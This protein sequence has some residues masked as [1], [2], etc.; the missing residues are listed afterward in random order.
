MVVVL[1]ALLVCGA[2]F[3]RSAH[4]HFWWEHVPGFFALFGLVGCVALALIAK[5][6]STPLL[7][8]DEDYYGD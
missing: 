2:I 1:S 8:R 6:L 5:A 7:H 3:G 4:P